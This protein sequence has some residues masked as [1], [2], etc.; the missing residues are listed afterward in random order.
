MSD[1]DSDEALSDDNVDNG[2]SPPNDSAKRCLYEFGKE[3]VSITCR[4]SHT[5]NEKLMIFAAKLTRIKNGNLPK[6]VF[7]R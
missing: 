4:L 2:P 7:K 1:V 6:F 3:M 5:F